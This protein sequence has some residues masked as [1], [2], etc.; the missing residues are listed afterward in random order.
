EWLAADA[1]ARASDD[2]TLGDGISCDPDGCV[3]ETA[4]GRFVARALQPTALADDCELAALVVSADAAS[5]DCGALVVDLAR[6]RR[7]GALALWRRQNG[8]AVE[9]VRPR[10][11]DRPWSPAPNNGADDD[12]MMLSRPAP[13][14]TPE[15]T[16]A[17][18]DMQTED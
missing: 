16:P 4:D 15:A 2:P 7:Q 12:T 18:V 1:D 14:R 3:A 6:I 8:F 17:E 11:F 5:P 9:A 10:G 13:A